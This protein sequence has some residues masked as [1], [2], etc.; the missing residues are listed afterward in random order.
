MYDRILYPWKWLDYIFGMFQ[1]LAKT[2]VC[3]RIWPNSY[4]QSRFKIL[5][6]PKLKENYRGFFTSLKKSVL[7]LTTHV[8]QIKAQLVSQ[9]VSQ[10]ILSGLCIT[11]PPLTAILST[12]TFS[13][14]T[15]VQFTATGILRR[16]KYSLMK[17]QNTENEVGS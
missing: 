10:S 5:R 11:P 3:L 4:D 14:D 2:R 17:I 8:N 1:T 13:V 6:S 15:L 16:H 7:M 9:S 12:Q